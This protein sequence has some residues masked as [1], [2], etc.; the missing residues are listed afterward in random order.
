MSEEN[1]ETIIPLW[2]DD[3]DRLWLNSVLSTDKN[4]KHINT[5]MSVWSMYKMLIGIKDITEDNSLYVRSVDKEMRRVAY[6]RVDEDLSLTMQCVG[7]GELFFLLTAQPL[8]TLLCGK[9]YLR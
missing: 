8:T 1:T 5:G 7:E 4:E 6:N 9:L 2:G 3:E